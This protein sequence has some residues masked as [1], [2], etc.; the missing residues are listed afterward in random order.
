MQRKQNLLAEY[1]MLKALQECKNVVRVF[2][3]IEDEDCNKCYMVLELLGE[4][5]QLST[6]YLK[7][8]V[9]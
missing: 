8:I 9:L 7:S 6:L 4:Y 1:H 3:F 5:I 2:D